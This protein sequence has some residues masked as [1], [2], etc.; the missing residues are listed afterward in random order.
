MRAPENCKRVNVVINKTMRFKHYKKNSQQYRDVIICRR[1]EI[2]D[3]CCWQNCT[4]LESLA[5]I[6]LDVMVNG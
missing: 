6:S 2:N 4:A 5:I 1:Q 3:V